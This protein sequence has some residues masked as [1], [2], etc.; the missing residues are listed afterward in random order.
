MGLERPNFNIELLALAIV[1]NR[2]AGFAKI[3]NPA[4]FFNL[5]GGAGFEPATS[6]VRICFCCFYGN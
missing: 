2:K 5:V 4:V 1:P 3:T 6:T